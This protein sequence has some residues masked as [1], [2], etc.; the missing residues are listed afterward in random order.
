LGQAGQNEDIR[1]SLSDLIGDTIC[2]GQVLDIGGIVLEVIDAPGHCLGGLAFWEPGEK[3]LFC[4]D[5]LGFIVPPDQIVPNF[6]VSYDD[7]MDTFRSL[8]FL[9]PSWICPGHCGVYS[10]KDAIEFI[11]LSKREMDWIYQRTIEHEQSSDPEDRQFLNELY[12][13]YFVGEA[14]MFSEESSRYC[15]SLLTRRILEAN[16]YNRTQ[17]NQKI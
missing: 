1:G 2:P 9:Q 3:V 13:R 14:T 5:Y 6:Y 17:S 12:H 4:S 11:N 15:V 10:G 8:T 16:S 7:F